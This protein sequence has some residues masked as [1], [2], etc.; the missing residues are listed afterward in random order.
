MADGLVIID[1]EDWSRVVRH[2]GARSFVGSD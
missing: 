2:D 1:D